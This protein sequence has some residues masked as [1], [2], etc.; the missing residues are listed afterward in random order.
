VSFRGSFDLDPV[1]TAFTDV[2]GAFEFINFDWSEMAYPRGCLDGGYTARMLMVAFTPL[3]A[4]V[5][6]P[7]VLVIIVVI[8]SLLFLTEKRA[9]ALA[10]NTVSR[11]EGDSSRNTSRR[12]SVGD[13]GGA[14]RLSRAFDDAG[15]ILELASSAGNADKRETK[16][17]TKSK[18]DRKAS[19][20]GTLTRIT[21]QVS[22]SSSTLTKRMSSTERLSRSPSAVKSGSGRSL[23]NVSSRSRAKS[24]DYARR[25]SV[26]S[27]ALAYK[28]VS[29][30]RARLLQI[31]PLV[32]LIVFVM[33]PSVSRTI[34][35]AWDCVAYKSGPTT[36]ISYIRRDMSV[37]CGSEEHNEVVVVAFFLV[38]LWPIGMQFLFF[39][40]LY[41]NRKILRTGEENAV[42]RA[43]RFLTGGYKPKYFYWETIELFRRLACSGFVVL[44]PHDKIFFRIAMAFLVSLPVLV[45]TAVLKPMRN[46]EDTALALCAQT[47]LVVA[48]AFC[49]VI[50]ILNTQDEA[51]TGHLKVLL[52]GFESP[53]VVMTMLA[54]CCLIFLLLL[55]GVYGY[56]MNEEFQKQVRRQDD[57]E[58]QE[59]SRWIF[60]G[61][62][63]GGFT[64]LAGG[65]TMYGL[66]GGIIATSIFFPLGGAAGSVLYA[67]CKGVKAGDPTTPYTPKTPGTDAPNTPRT[68][69]NQAWDTPMVHVDGVHVQAVKPE[70]LKTVQLNLGAAEQD[71]PKSVKLEAG[72]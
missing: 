35:S 37:E 18:T 48:Y 49:M 61:G 25:K 1:N 67:K 26:D 57:A 54:I 65:G 17:E 22:A 60:I 71:T 21:S 12:P 43:L 14:I 41:T 4:I 23:S 30:I 64:A 7:A 16:R 38:L 52:V 70:S 19:L 68:P 34:F 10:R 28:K 6:I 11:A 42:S 44:I 58:A 45:L 13:A 53:E 32:V 69:D 8:V 3:I 72:D 40:C 56:K 9:T 15:R 62:S 55:I 66:V 36:S 39:S 47:I 31:L 27:F 20:V 46:P 29:K 51:L 2:F 33:L 50:H 63:I 59:S 24:V 5:V